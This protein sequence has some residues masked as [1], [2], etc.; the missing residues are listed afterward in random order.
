MK[1]ISLYFSICLLI[2][3][4]PVIIFAG[5]KNTFVK[6]TYQ[7]TRT[8][9]PASCFDSSC[10]MKI[11]NIFETLV[12]FNGQSSESFVP[13]LATK[14]PTLKNGGITEDGTLY[15]FYIRKGVKFHNGETLIPE[16]VEYSLERNMLVD[17]VNG[18]SGMLLKAILGNEYQSTRKN[19]KIIPGIM[20][21]IMDAIVLKGNTISIKLSAPFPPLL[22]ILQGSW[23]SI[24]S[25]KW[26]IANKAWDGTLESASKQQKDGGYNAP[27]INTE[28]LQ[29]ISNGT[30]AYQLKSWEKSNQIILEAF[31]QYWGKKP[32]IQ[33]AIIEYLPE[34]TSLKL[35]L[36]NGDAD[37]VTVSNTFV[38]EIKRIQDITIYKI[39]Q[40]TASFALFNHKINAKNNLDIGSG[41]LD[42]KGIPT[43]FFTDINIRL[44]FLHA[45]DY[46]VLKEDVGNNLVLNPGSPNIKGLPYFKKI[47]M[48]PF[49]L[50]KS[51]NYLKKAFNGDVWRK[52]FQMTITHQYDS[53][54]YEAVALMM[55]ENMNTLSPKINIKVQKI[56]PKD[57]IEKYQQSLFP[58]FFV[59]WKAEYPDPHNFLPTFMHSKGI[60]G[61][62]SHYYNPEVDKLCEEGAMTSDPVKRKKIYTQLQNIW[63][64]DAV[65]VGLQQ[66]LL[67]KIYRSNISGFVPNAVFDDEYEL[68][69]VLKKR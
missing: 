31:D 33:T 40:L 25:K 61:R 69:R 35:K 20:K 56:N 2:L 27:Q 34:W 66:P 36:L 6:G 30:G 10:G 3:L 28:P 50:E 21:K 53:T 57:Y 48:F 62:F 5:N 44:S 14:V 15:T 4:S 37:T 64:T 51:K 16:D 41:K 24:V 38:S 67:V 29:A 39:P 11:R 7:T 65:G 18:P 55:A 17:Q 42:G 13:L 8:L 22:A 19:G 59:H 47:P 12:Q 60:N 45:I 26:A 52:G 49:D 46:K 43:D 54:F 58:V 9:D 32:Y 1:N 23:G 68:L 63:K